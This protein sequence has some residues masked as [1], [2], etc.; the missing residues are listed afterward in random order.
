MV[1]CP[2]FSA[3]VILPI[4]ASIR[5]DLPDNG[6]VTWLPRRMHESRI[7]FRR[8]SQFRPRAAPRHDGPGPVDGAGA[9]HAVLSVGRAVRG[10]RRDRLRADTSQQLESALL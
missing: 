6:V 2:S 1:I 9:Q 10:H 8:D 4:R 3:K 7:E 5:F